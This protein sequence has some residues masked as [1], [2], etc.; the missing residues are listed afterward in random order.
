MPL[1]IRLAT[2]DDAAIITEQRSAMFVDMGTP[3]DD[4]LAE[5]SRRFWVSLALTLRL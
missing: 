5:M 4:T 3:D 2:V 1:D